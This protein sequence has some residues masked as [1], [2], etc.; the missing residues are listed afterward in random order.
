[1]SID[2]IRLNCVLG[3][4]RR[5]GALA[6]TLDSGRRA[7]CLFSDGPRAL[8]FRDG[9]PLLDS[10]KHEWGYVVLSQEELARFFRRQS[11]DLVACAPVAASESVDCVEAT[12]LLEM[13]NRGDSEAELQSCTRADLR[14]SERSDSQ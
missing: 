13:L 11:A 8:E 7:W 14:N 10:D 2:I 12:V 9:D 3:H 1:M 5:R 4:R 6:I